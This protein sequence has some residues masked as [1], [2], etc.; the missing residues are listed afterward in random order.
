[1]DTNQEQT[2]FQVGNYIV[3]PPGIGLPSRSDISQF[4]RITQIVKYKGGGF[5]RTN[6]NIEIPFE[7]W[8]KLIL[9]TKQ[10]IELIMGFL[11]LDLESEDHE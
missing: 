4:V 11:N 2:E 7:Q 9:V 3:V 8:P 10:E 6:S 1:M 5:V